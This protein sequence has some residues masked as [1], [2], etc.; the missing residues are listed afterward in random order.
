[1]MK[2]RSYSGQKKILVIE[3]EPLIRQ[4]LRRYLGIIGY[5]VIDCARGDEAL[6]IIAEEDPDAL[7]ID[8]HL[9]DIDGLELYRT[10]LSNNGQVPA[11][12]ISAYQL[13]KDELKLAAKLGVKG[14]LRK[15]FG[16]QHLKKILRGAFSRSIFRRARTSFQMK[17]PSYNLNP[18]FLAREVFRKVFRQGLDMGGHVH[19]HA[20]GFSDH[21]ILLCSRHTM[22]KVIAK[23]PQCGK[24]ECVK[25]ER[26]SFSQF[27]PDK[28]FSEIGQ[29]I[30]L[31]RVDA[32]DYEMSWPTL[33]DFLCWLQL[34][35]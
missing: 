29:K 24:G 22:G 19:F 12:L 28:I 16:F 1:M 34:N 31:V 27:D 2:P 20:E 14:F 23:S 4:V 25:W 6:E 3:D 26:S 15:P 8:H 21:I 10:I 32:A 11:V 33:A 30:N 13:S 7:I 35:Y 9:P 5:Q 18:R 17:E